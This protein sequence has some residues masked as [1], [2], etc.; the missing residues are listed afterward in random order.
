MRKRELKGIK[1]G[2]IVI[3]IKDRD[4]SGCVLFPVGTIGRIVTIETD[5]NLPYRIESLDGREGWW[6]EEGSFVK[7]SDEIKKFTEAFNSLRANLS[8]KSSY[9][10]NKDEDN[11]IIYWV[12]VNTALQDFMSD[13]FREERG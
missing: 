3:T 13:L 2:D 9:L 7:S 12:D 1:L 5:N 8:S 11:R 10:R 4:P 6:Y